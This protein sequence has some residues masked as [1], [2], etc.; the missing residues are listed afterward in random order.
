MVRVVVRVMVRV[1][2]GWPAVAHGGGR[3]APVE[4]VRYGVGGG[5]R[6]PRR[7][8]VPVLAERGAVGGQG[9]ILDSPGESGLVLSEEGN[10]AGLSSNVGDPGLILRLGRS[11]GRGNGNP[12]QYSCLENPPGEPD[13][14]RLS[15]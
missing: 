12:L 11:L 10:P 14:L 6:A 4:A 5:R 15:V 1:V 7:V 9:C 13:G 3:G 8:A 2:I